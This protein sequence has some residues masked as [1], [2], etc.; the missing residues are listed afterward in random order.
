MFKGEVL[1]PNGWITPRE[2][3]VIA[4]MGGNGNIVWQKI[5]K[6]E[7]ANGEFMHVGSNYLSYA[8]SLDHKIA[9]C[10][11]SRIATQMDMIGFSS[12]VKLIS[13]SEIYRL[14]CQSPSR[15]VKIHHIT[16]AYP[17]SLPCNKASTIK[18]FALSHLG[19]KVVS[20]RALSIFRRYLDYRLVYPSAYLITDYADDPFKMCQSDATELVSLLFPMMRNHDNSRKPKPESPA[21]SYKTPASSLLQ[22]SCFFAGITSVVKNEVVKIYLHGRKGKYPVRPTITPA[23]KVELYHDSGWNIDVNHPVV[24][25]NGKVVVL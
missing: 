4:C 20:E 22:M 17:E 9:H 6:A 16:N 24:R 11:D 5:K 8:I 2:G 12:R 21:R 18:E 14:W 19:S 23:T 7:M 15:Q 1:T 10:R 3:E 25:L 13:G